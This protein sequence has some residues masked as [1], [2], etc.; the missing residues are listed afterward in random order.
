VIRINL[1]EETRVSAQKKSSGGGLA[2]PKVQLAENVPVFMLV[3]GIALAAGIV[4]I[5]SMVLYKQSHDLDASIEKAKIE[6][7]RLE[8]VLK[9]ND[10]L[11]RKKEDLNRKIGVIA[12]LKRKQ[13]LPVQLLDLISRNLADFVWLEEMTFTGEVV[14]I[15]G[16]A[17]TPIAL[18]NFL[19]NLEESKYFR[20]VA[21]GTVTNEPSTGLTKFEA[22]MIF[23]P[24]GQQ[25]GPPPGAAAEKPAS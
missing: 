9:R 15:H 22:T 19:R 25:A 2:M 24:S 14:T 1:L 13:A 17:Q 18:A 7:K 11:N 10:E 3:G 21:M 16:K 5:W 23:N 4:G 20:E 8:Y 6:Q 12:D